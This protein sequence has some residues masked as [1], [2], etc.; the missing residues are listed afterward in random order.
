[1]TALPQASLVLL[2]AHL[3]DLD[4]PVLGANA[5]AFAAGRVLAVGSAEAL[6][7][8]VGSGTTVESLGGRTV[9][10]AF[11]DAHL[12]LELYA[13]SLDQV[14]CET[15]S[16]DECIDRLRQRALASPPGKWI[17]GHGWNQNEWGCPPATDSLNQAVPHHPVFATAKSLHA[18]WANASALRLAHIHAETPDPEGG[19]LL[20]D[21]SGAPNGVL[22]ESACGLVARHVPS[23]D[24]EELC[25]LVEG[26]QRSLWKVG[27]AGVHDFDGPR[28]LQTVQR[29]RHVGALGLRILKSIPR[30][31]LADAI[32]LGIS[33]GLGDHWIRL[34]HVKLFADGALGSRTAA[35]LSPYEGE[36][37]N[38]G[39]LLLD[40]EAIFETGRQAAAAG[41][42]LAV[43]AI[44]DRATHAVIGALRALQQ[45]SSP[46][47]RLQPHR[48][49]HLQL[50][51]PQD[52]EGLGELHCVASM[53]PIHAP[54]DMQMA[55]R[56]WGSR[57]RYAYAWKT[58]LHAGMT[59]A[60][61]SDAPVEDPNPLLGLHAAV[62][63]RRDDG[64]PGADGWGPEEKLSLREAL[65]A[66]T[67]GPARASGSAQ[68]QGALRPG[69]LGDLV[70]LNADPF[71]L[72]LEELPGLRVLG[73]MVD[74][75]WRHRDF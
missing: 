50:L 32:S 54:S 53:Q 5:I 26:A 20:R 35:M 55:D 28:L 59:L 18:G 61:G 38:R 70:V 22:L 2:D 15:R 34:G 29:L 36:P 56:Y 60:F 69:Y 31:R 67:L 21:S 9:L 10:P 17:L 33:A 73:T 42:S 48:I 46:W 25:A 43:H 51:H 6:T 47:P 74:A 44:G 52:L 40:E 75:V 27:I 72:A 13:R 16:V 7:P 37:D 14:N 45:E 41:L 12:H 3:T 24:Q 68:E 65:L 39:V 66:Y 64:S 1:M 8:L 4:G 62:T 58:A 11:S 19:Q 23:P 49:E 71:A 30:E 63:R 57:T